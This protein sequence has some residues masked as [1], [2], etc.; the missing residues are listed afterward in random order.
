MLRE[1]TA[2]AGFRGIYFT[3]SVADS[4]DLNLY[5]CL[6]IGATLTVSGCIFA[7]AGLS[8][9]RLGRS[10]VGTWIDLEGVEIQAKH[11]VLTRG[12]RL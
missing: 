11:D 4:V 9:I 12:R 2:R 5:G 1:I 8:L 6:L 7:Y 10:P 3:T